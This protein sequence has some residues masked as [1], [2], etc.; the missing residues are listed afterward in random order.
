MA[1]QALVASAG[2]GVFAL[3]LRLINL[4]GRS[5][6][7]DES[8]SVW[9]AGQ[10]VSDIVRHVDFHPPLYYL[11]LK[12]WLSLGAWAAGDI[13]VRLPSAIASA[14]SVV[15]GVWMLAR[16][17]RAAALLFGALSSTSALL[18]W[19]GQEA[20]MYA[21]ASLAVTI[22]LTQLAVIV[23][24]ERTRERS[25]AGPWLMYGV[26]SLA[27]LYLHYDAALLLS[28]AGLIYLWANRQNGRRLLGW[29]GVHAL[30]ALA[31]LP[32]MARLIDTFERVNT[33]HIIENAPVALAALAVGVLGGAAVVGLVIWRAGPARAAVAL[34]VLVILGLAVADL[35]TYG[36]S[37]KRHIAIVTPVALM[38]AS[39]VLTRARLPAVARAG[40]VLVGVPALIL[41][42]VV[43]P[44]EDWRGVATYLDAAARPDDELVV[45]QGYTDVALRRYYHGSPRTVPVYSA[46][47]EVL[48]GL[49]PSASVW[50]V[51]SHTTEP[52]TLAASLARA[53]PLIESREFYRV[54]VR[55]FGP[56]RAARRVAPDD[57]S[58]ARGSMA[59]RGSAS[60]G[61]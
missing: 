43:H 34:A 41:V 53:R 6:W 25:V 9:L 58:E 38:G 12:V 59:G 42:L 19:Y 49:D 46:S 37:I 23:R 60:A 20:R 22:A 21:L 1:R 52:P 16:V 18:A 57:G 35:T 26:A 11:L 54:A 51:E 61:S 27:A 44:K 4:G 15:V 50:L 32:Q 2:F 45:Y 7:L 13:G 28:A 36:V 10:P 56:E 39:L 31:F 47:I 3:V 5:L 17:D 8:Y 30:L 14:L 33:L 29:T 55:H 40:L 48:T 24:L